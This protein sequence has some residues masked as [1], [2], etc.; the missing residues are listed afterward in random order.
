[1]KKFHCFLKSIRTFIKNSCYNCFLFI[2]LI[3]VVYNSNATRHFE[4]CARDNGNP[5]TNE[6]LAFK[7]YGILDLVGNVGNY[8]LTDCKDSFQN[9]SS[10]VVASSNPEVANTQARLLI[11]EDFESGKMTLPRSGNYPTITTAP[12]RAGKYAMKTYLHYK[13]SPVNYR[14]EIQLTDPKLEA[15]FGKNYWY[16]F[17]IFLPNDYIP[18][19][20]WE[21]V[22]Q[23][24]G[25]PDGYPDF[26]PG[27]E[28]WRN[29]IM[30][31]RT[32]GG[33]WDVFNTWDSKT[34]TGWIDKDETD[35]RVYGGSS[36]WD[37]GAYKT[38]RWVDWVFHVKWSYQSNGILEVWKNGELVISRKGPNCFNDRRGPYFKMGI[39]KGWQYWW[40]NDW[41]FDVAKE[42]TL[43]H[44]ELRIAKGKDGYTV[45]S[46]CDI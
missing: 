40:K 12:V 1:M 21:I 45:V 22:A 38:E 31:L 4:S 6:G 15:K 27:T 20:V 36:T 9:H 24:H 17:S 23:W 43:Y 3:L 33:K 16:G 39:Y 37:L 11:T 18:D 46:P 41:S 42:R 30:A 14:T 7:S 32:T 26:A 13:N 35:H 29:P 8:S 2:V 28:Y 10:Q 19:N 44:D 34:N 5:G 25:R